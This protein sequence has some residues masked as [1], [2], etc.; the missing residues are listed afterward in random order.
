MKKHKIL[1]M[2]IVILALLLAYGCFV[3]FYFLN[4]EVSEKFCEN[5]TIN[6]YQVSGMNVEEAAQ[7]LKEQYSGYQFELVETGEVVLSK[8]LE[9]LG[10]DLN[11]EELSAKVTKLMLSQKD[12]LI[13]S[14]MKGNAFDMTFPV[15]IDEKV[16]KK[17]IKA[18][19]LSVPRVASVDAQLSYDGQS[20]SITPEVYGNEFANKDLRAIVKETIEDALSG[21]MAGN[22]TITAEIPKEIYYLPA[23]K[24]DAPELVNTM[25]IYNKYA[26]AKIE[27]V[28]GPQVVTLD[29]NTIKDWIIIDGSNGSIS[30]E[31]AYEYVINMSLKYD[32]I[33]T[34]R[35]F[36]ASD[37]RTI[38]L[39]SNDYG[40]R[41]DRDGEF[42]QMIADINANTVTQREPV[43]SIKGYA[44][45]GRDDLCGTY[46]EVNLSA[47]HLWFYKNG[48]LLVESD[49]VSGLPKDGRETTTG[50]FPIA[51]KQSP[52]VLEG[53]S[54]EGAWSEPVDYWMPF[55]EG[56]GLHD[57]PWRS[58]FGGD[59]YKTNGS[60]G[61]I[62]LPGWAAA[63][64][65]ES[66]ES[67]IPILLYK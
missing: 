16:F 33:Y 32:T 13:K 57:A 49:F 45:N 46:V 66:M 42:A 26:A 40:Y 52:A 23:V 10:Y 47:Q 8:T 20:Y 44:R 37:G 65:F 61:C 19:K 63:A 3:I 60:H 12:K 39:P 67:R 27:Y 15:H 17:R 43:Y 50:A 35:S 36:T 11:E 4:K 1:K 14:Y 2:V 59:I 55:H 30:D 7:V 6:G 54:G 31:K 51:Y 62:N 38:T 56:Q 58:S 34:E 64:I 48:A 9:Q 28:F 41:I 25:N 24:Q 53:G 21:E 5:T 18:S 29:W 22:S